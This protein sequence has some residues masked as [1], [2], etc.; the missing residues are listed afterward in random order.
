MRKIIR[1]AQTEPFIEREDDDMIICRCE[2]ITKGEIR[3]A[4]YLAAA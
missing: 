2:E 4:E 1:A 3:R